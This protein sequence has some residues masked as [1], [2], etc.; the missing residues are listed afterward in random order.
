MPFSRSRNKSAIDQMKKG[1]P[2]IDRPVDLLAQ[3]FITLSRIE[4]ETEREYICVYR[5]D[6]V[7][8]LGK[9]SEALFFTSLDNCVLMS[10]HI[11]LYTLK[12]PDAHTC[13]F[14][15]MQTRKSNGSLISHLLNW[16]CF[17]SIQISCHYT[18]I[19]LIECLLI[20][21]N[22]CRCTAKG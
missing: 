3:A 11:Q 18:E 8:S 20:W 13:V 9:V 17:F 21:L 14:P 16:L 15:Q 1:C 2:L 12:V 5:G 10:C 4:W 7:L 22:R 19:H 6:D